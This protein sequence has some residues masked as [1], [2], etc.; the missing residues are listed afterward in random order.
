SFGFKLITIFYIA[1]LGFALV[2]FPDLFAG[3]S[4]VLL[5]WAAL[6]IVMKV[7]AIIGIYL[8]RWGK[9]IIAWMIVSPL[10]ALAYLVKVWAFTES[11]SKSGG[12]ALPLVSWSAVAS[13]L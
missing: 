5:A 3:S 13:V 2:E 9:L 4:T 1:A 11:G 7:L 12:A 10:A 8:K 6:S